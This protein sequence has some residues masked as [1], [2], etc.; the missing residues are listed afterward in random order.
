MGQQPSGDKEHEMHDVHNQ[1]HRLR[2]DNQP[3]AILQRKGMGVGWVEDGMRESE[4][5]LV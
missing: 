1:F 2:T 4:R 3:E 5:P